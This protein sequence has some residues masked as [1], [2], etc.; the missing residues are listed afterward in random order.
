MARWKIH[1]QHNECSSQAGSGKDGDRS[2]APRLGLALHWGRLSSGARLPPSR[3]SP[4]FSRDGSHRLHPG[5]PVSRAQ[6][7]PHA[8]A[9]PARAEELPRAAKKPGTPHCSPCGSQ[10]GGGMSQLHLFSILL[11]LLLCCQVRMGHPARRCSAPHPAHCLP[12]SCHRAAPLHGSP[13]PWH[14]VQWMLPFPVC[15]ATH[16][17]WHRCTAWHLSPHSPMAIPALE[18]LPCPAQWTPEARVTLPGTPRVP[19]PRSWISSLRAGRHTVRS[20]TAT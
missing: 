14:T 6:G 18:S 5:D 19:L 12:L 16:M 8:R 7:H 17:A 20:A 3:L 4:S 10:P 2:M 9:L 13:W 11:L 1:K 15:T